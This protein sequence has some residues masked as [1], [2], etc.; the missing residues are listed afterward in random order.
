MV[1]HPG[2][3]VALLVL[4]SSATIAA[5]PPKTDKEPVEIVGRAEDYF[6]TRNY[7]SYYWRED[8]S[9]VLKADD[10]KAWRVISREPTPAYDWR[11]GPTYTGLKVN[12]A[13][14]PR[15]KVFG[16]R[17]V[18]RIP[19][20]FYDFKLDEPNL[21]TAL[22]VWVETKPDVWQEFYVNNW[23]HRWGEK[24]DAAVH[25][26]Y[27]GRPA[28]YDVYGF[29]AGQ[30]A[31]FGKASQ[32][33]IEKNPKAKMFHGLVKEAKDNPF[34]YEIELLHLVGPDAGGNGVVMYGD[35]STIPALDKK[36][37]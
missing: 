21:A 35:P 5:D 26:L 34:G 4:A 30:T 16:V 12:W 27:A 31:P 37:P 7:S 25:K 3:S 17:G 29:I 13:E 32:A 24:A 28:P 10:G 33:L 19:A 11:M 2:L 36:K 8:F 6:S 23:L 1:R 18:D 14:K 15:V 20:T 22:V 9:F